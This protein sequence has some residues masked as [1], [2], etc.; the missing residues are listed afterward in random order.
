MEIS[1]HAIKYEIIMFQNIASLLIYQQLVFSF[2]HL[3]PA[4]IIFTFCYYMEVVLTPTL[5]SALMH[6][7][8][9]DSIRFVLADFEVV[10]IS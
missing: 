1:K 8:H 5:N 6:T 7:V 2:R 3:F 4:V 10:E 9:Y